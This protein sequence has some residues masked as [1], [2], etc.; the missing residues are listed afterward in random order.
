MET[1]KLSRDE[2][3][4]HESRPHVEIEMREEASDR[5]DDEEQKHRIR[6]ESDQ[7]DETDVD[8]LADDEIVQRVA[9]RVHQDIDAIRQMMGG[10]DAPHEAAERPRS[11]MHPAMNPVLHE[12]EDEDRER[13]GDIKRQ[14]GDGADARPRDVDREHGAERTRG[15]AGSDARRDVFGIAQETPGGHAPF[16]FCRKNRFEKNERERGRADNGPGRRSEIP[17]AMKR[18]KRGAERTEKEHGIDGSCDD[19]FRA[20]QGPF[21]V[22]HLSSPSVVRERATGHRWRRAHVRLP[23]RGHRCRDVRRAP[24]CGAPRR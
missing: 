6:V 23:L 11:L 22:F 5:R 14:I 8:R 10:V 18:E 17:A 7:L 4:V 21:S 15:R 12:I 20:R 3:I 9:G 13:H 1:M 19:I 2:E 16:G 24:R